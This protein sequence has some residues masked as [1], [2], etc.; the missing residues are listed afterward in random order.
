M[1]LGVVKN[2]LIIMLEIEL[3]SMVLMLFV[4]IM[5]RFC[6]LVWIVGLFCDFMN[7]E[8]EILKKLNVML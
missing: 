2:V 3:L 6:V 4:I 8:F 5:N 7:K 1:L